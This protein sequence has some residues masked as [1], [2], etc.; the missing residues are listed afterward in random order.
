MARIR[1]P[2][3]RVRNAV[4][5]DGDNRAD[6]AR[7]GEKRLRVH[8]RGDAIGN[9]PGVALDDLVAQPVQRVLRARPSESLVDFRADMIVRDH[10]EGRVL[11][12]RIGVDPASVRIGVEHDV[13][14]IDLGIGEHADEGSR[15]QVVPQLQPGA[16]H[17]E[18]AGARGRVPDDANVA[19]RAN[20]LS[21]DD[22]SRSLRDR[23]QDASSGVGRW[24]SGA[25]GSGALAVLVRLHSDLAGIAIARDDSAGDVQI[26]GDRHGVARA[27]NRGRPPAVS[28][29]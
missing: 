23:L 1:I 25:R 16:E 5:R 3:T 8:R 19:H 7:A 15:L 11:Q 24:R 17:V 10:G 4:R 29:T 20:R 2:A 6:A 12:R 27:G 21:T 18:V 13:A 22:A 14:G 28:Q 26:A 9:H